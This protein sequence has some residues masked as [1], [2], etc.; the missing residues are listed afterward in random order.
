MWIEPV[1]VRQCFSWG[2][3]MHL[4]ISSLKSLTLQLHHLLCFI[5]FQST[6]L[7]SQVLRFVSVYFFYSGLVKHCLASCSFPSLF[8]LSPASVMSA[9]GAACGRQL[10]LCWPFQPVWVRPLSL[11][12]ATWGSSAHR[13]P[14]SQTLHP[15]KKKFCMVQSH[16]CFNSPIHSTSFGIFMALGLNGFQE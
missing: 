5:H 8:P 10:A 9:L 15:G 1:L 7:I 4:Q 3:I 13:W 14:W 2:I 11:P 12:W 6:A 16:G